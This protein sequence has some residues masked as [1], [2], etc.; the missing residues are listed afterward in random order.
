M[1]FQ[2]EE[3]V[4]EHT[5]SGRWG[6][7]AVSGL[8]LTLHDYEYLIVCFKIEDTFCFLVAWWQMGRNDEGLCCDH[9]RAVTLPGCYPSPQRCK[10]K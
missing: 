2:H 10:E 9:P 4:Y 3:D 6:I 5:M 1:L 7:P 8:I